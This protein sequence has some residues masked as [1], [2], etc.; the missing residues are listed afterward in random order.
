MAIED[1][2]SKLPK[3]PKDVPEWIRTYCA[4]GTYHI[5]S[6]KDDYKICTRCGTPSRCHGDER[7]NGVDE[8]ACGHSVMCKSAGMGRQ[9]LNEYFRVM[10]FTRRGKKVYV[11]VSGVT[12]D[13]SPFGQP[14]IHQ[15]PTC[16]YTFDRKGSHYYKYDWWSCSWSEIDNIKV[17]H[18]PRG[19]WW[20]EP[21]FEEIYIYDNNLKDVFLKSDLKYLWDEEFIKYQDA[22][23]LIQYIKLGMQYQSI[24]LLL[25]AGFSQLVWDKISNT[26]PS[27]AVWWKGKTLQ[28]ILRLNMG[29]IRKIRE[30]NPNLSTLKVYQKLSDAEKKTTPWGAVA[31]CAKLRTDQLD[32]L[33]KYSTPIKV[34]K[35]AQKHAENDAYGIYGF[36]ID[37]SDYVEAAKKIGLDVKKKSVLFP[38]DFKQA[39]DTATAA[40]AEMKN[41]GV[42]KKIKER[43][44]GIE[45]EKNG[46]MVLEADSVKSLNLESAQLNHCVRTY[47]DKVAAGRCRIFFIRQI[48]NPDKSF[49]TLEADPKG[50]FVQCRGNRNCSMTDEV[51]V[52]TDE[53]IKKLGKEIKKARA[54]A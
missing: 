34:M 53:F 47:A 54:T 25:K 15:S 21:K 1:I 19:C 52:F 33:A 9:N 44:L 6:K 42:S 51:K 17:P 48:E 46:L 22:Y 7:H 12:L 5:Y 18:M 20:G 26:G 38:S 13:F 35:Y 4:T 23:Q 43:M 41:A 11:T 40:A 10:V 28:K 14:A 3:A 8:C 24:E 49:Y 27:G 31:D 32:K 50:K 29:D 36:V 37:W 2:I 45:F 16:V 30:H 39:H